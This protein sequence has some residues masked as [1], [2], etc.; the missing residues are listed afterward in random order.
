MNIRV[1]RARLLESIRARGAA[2]GE[3]ALR[4]IVHVW[5]QAHPD[6]SAQPLFALVEAL[7][8]SGSREARLAALCLLTC[9]PHHVPALGWE[10]FERWRRDL[11]SRA[12]TDVLAQEILGAWLLSH[13]A[14]HFGH[15]WDQLIRGN[16]WNRRLALVATTWLNQ[17]HEDVNHPGVTLF[18][19]DQVKRV[20]GAVITEAIAWAL[21]ALGKVRP[22]AVLTY[23]NRNRLTLEEDVIRSVEERLHVSS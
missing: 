18:L 2:P 6:L 7:W 15:L 12:L 1:E 23:L 19:V 4:E 3:P 21:R 13:P 9:Y 11:E 10:H 5:Q 22:D 16:R 14:H 17:A 8:D 20:H